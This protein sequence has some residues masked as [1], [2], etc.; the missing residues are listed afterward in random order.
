MDQKRSYSNFSYTE[1]FELMKEFLEY[2]LKLIVDH[3]QDLNI[4]EN[5]TGETAVNFTI[6]ANGEDIGKIIG[7]EGK[8]IQA[9]RNLLKVLA[10]K[11]N[12]QVHLEVV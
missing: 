11:E 5:V 2:V 9:L 6:H 4:E 10:V 12:K 1:T 8:I 3:P 7:K